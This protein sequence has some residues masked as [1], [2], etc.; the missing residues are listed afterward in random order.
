MIG[1]IKNAIV[2]LVE[3]QADANAKAMSRLDTNLFHQLQKIAIA[4]TLPYIEENMS[5]AVCMKNS[6]EMFDYI[7]P[8]TE[9]QGMILEFGVFK[10]RTITRIAK[11]TNQTVYG[12]DSFE[13]LPE[14]WSGWKHPAGYFSLGGQAP[15]VPKNVTLIKGWFDTALPKFLD[16]H[17]ENI[18]FLHIHC[19]LYSSTKTV[20]D[21]LK[22]RIT[23]K[24]IIMF[25]EYFAYHGWKHHEFRAFQEF[26]ER[27]NVDYTYLAYAS[28]EAGHVC[29][30]IDKI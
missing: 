23:D 11:G 17:P 22:D 20:L 5:G 13:G 25:H 28:S 10:G 26:V 6:F 8:K 7:L 3:I 16:Q 18:A 24:T 4:E 12:F 27:Y 19:D 1:R 14:D 9:N 21:C 29:L 2:N 15:S 30:R